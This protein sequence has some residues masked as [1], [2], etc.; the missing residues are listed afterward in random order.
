VIRRPIGS[1]SS[2][3]PP[4]PPPAELHQTGREPIPTTQLQHVRTPTPPNE[5]AISFDQPRSPS[6]HHSP[7]IRPKSYKPI[8]TSPIQT[9]KSPG[10]IP[11]LKRP[12][13]K[14]GTPSQPP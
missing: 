13:S 1:E 3:R 5:A 2:A 7:S 6:P 9:E 8:T 4:P 14:V 11:Y 12:R 10:Y